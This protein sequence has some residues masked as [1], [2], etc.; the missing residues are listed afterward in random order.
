MLRCTPTG[1]EV[2][3]DQRD[4][5][6]RAQELALEDARGVVTPGGNEPRRKE[7]ENEEELSPE[8]AT[9]Y[10]GIVARAKYLAAHRPDLM[11]AVKGLCR[12]RSKPSN[13]DCLQLKR[14]G[15]HLVKSGRTVMKNDWQGHYH[16]VTGCSDS[17]WAGC[18]VTGKS[19]S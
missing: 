19:A 1:W 5:D 15:R 2:E 3:A 8:E 17:D 16:W 10:R 4:A 6:L 14:L 7:G 11:H 12:G 18:R 13:G 9:R